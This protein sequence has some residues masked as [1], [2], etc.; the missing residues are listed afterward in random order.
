MEIMEIR[1]C[2]I[3]VNMLCKYVICA[4]RFFP[5]KYLLTLTPDSF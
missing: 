1:V 4:Q 5:S 3:L 2:S